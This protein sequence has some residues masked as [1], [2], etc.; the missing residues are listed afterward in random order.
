M[1]IDKP[2]REQIPQL[3]QLWKEAFGDSDAYLDSFFSLAFAPER[4]CCVT[5]EGRVKA[6]LYW[7]ECGCRGRELAY[8]YA[9]ATEMAS[10]GRGL[11]RKLMTHVHRVL[12]EQD[13]AGAVLVPATEDLEQMYA[14]MGYL[15]ATAVTEFTCLAG[16]EPAG[17]QMLTAAEYAKR[18]RERLPEGGVLQEG[19]MLDLLAD[20]CCLVGGEDFLLAAWTED[21]ILHGEEFLGSTAAAPGIVKAL[22]AQ[23]GR[24]RMPGDTQPFAMY[25]PLSDDCPKPDYFGISLG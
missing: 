8:L 11:C 3:R 6:A 20:Q 10:R 16:E 7:F 4:C 9:V 19:A 24:F 14:R 23:K 15:P 21:G 18:R 12:K 22:G 25:L 1:T 5:E 17:L 13:Y 2:K